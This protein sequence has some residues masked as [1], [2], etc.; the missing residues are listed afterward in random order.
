MTNKKYIYSFGA[1]AADGDASMRELLGGKGANLAEMSRL[2]L[3]VPPGFTVTTDVCRNYLTRGSISKARI[4]DIK[5]SVRWLEDVSGKKLGDTKNPLLVSVRSGAQISMP[6]MMETILNIGLND[7]AVSALAQISGA[8]FA[9]DCYARL[10]EMYSRVVGEELPQDPWTQIMEATTAVFQSWNNPHAIA[11]RRDMDIS[12][13][14]GTAVTIQQMVFGNLNENSGTGVYLTRNKNTG[15]NTPTGEWLTLAQ[16]E[17][18]VAGAII[19]QSIEVFAKKHPKLFRKL[20]KIGEDLELHF[21]DMQDIEYTVENGKL[22]VLQTR[23]AKPPPCGPCKNCSKFCRRRFD[24][25]RR[26]DSADKPR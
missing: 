24:L 7:Q 21:R 17:D 18:V 19:P 23:A 12:Q 20:K 9:D 4:S 5:Q 3:P 1:G 8:D 22:Y 16:G 15:A 13:D 2:A 11:F 10:K 6:G 26:G 14:L 25:E